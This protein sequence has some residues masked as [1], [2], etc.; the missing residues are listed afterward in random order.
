MAFN[1][2]I[3]VNQPLTEV[4]V[5]FMQELDSFVAD[6]ACPV[7]KVKKE[8]D[9]YYVY[10]REHF[11]NSPGGLDRANGAVAKE[12]DLSYSTSSYQLME[13]SGRMLVTDRDKANADQALQRSE[14]HTSE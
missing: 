11:V 12:V 14:E 2:T 9:L 1:G 6:K 3:H 4:S 10:G 8:S 7:V 5:S 13:I